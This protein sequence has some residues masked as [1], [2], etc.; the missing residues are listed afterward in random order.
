MRG[1][2]VEDAPKA[3]M[4]IGPVVDPTEPIRTGLT[5]APARAKARSSRSAAN[6]STGPPPASTWPRLF[7]D[8]DNTMRIWR[9]E[10]FGPVSTMIPARDY[11]HTSEI[12]RHGI[13]PLRR[14]L[15]DEPEACVALQAQ[16]RGGHGDGQPADGG[17]RLSRT[18]RRPKGSNL[19]P[20][21]QGRYA[22]EFY[23]T[24]KTAYT[25]EP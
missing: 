16:H 25:H 1:L 18:V 6:G 24:V 22:A 11:D 5:S 13:R 19:G 9:E 12:E 10:I 20:R 7:L 4:Q 15:H 8:A 2:V 21:E 23:T 3:G 14:H 17:R